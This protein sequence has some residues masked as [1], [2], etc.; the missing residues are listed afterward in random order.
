MSNSQPKVLPSYS[1][2]DKLLIG[3]TNKTLND[4]ITEN[5]TL[6]EQ[7]AAMKNEITNLKER[8]LQLWFAPGAPGY[9]EALD[10]WEQS[11]E[12]ITINQ[13]KVSQPQIV[14]IP[15]AECFNIDS[16]FKD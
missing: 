11:I 9:L 1:L 3:Q 7:L 4:L 8:V 5:I 6:H 13:C 15:E 2:N 10:H 14:G 12:G 16:L